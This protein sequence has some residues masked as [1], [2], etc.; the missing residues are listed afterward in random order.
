MNQKMWQY[1]TIV[2][3]VAVFILLIFT[4]LSFR[5][6][7]REC[8]LSPE[9]YIIERMAKANKAGVMCQCKTDSHPIATKTWYSKDYKFSAIDFSN[10]TI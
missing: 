3:L 5:K 1:L 4:L 10:I 8:V 2:L 7:A 9:N 6:Q